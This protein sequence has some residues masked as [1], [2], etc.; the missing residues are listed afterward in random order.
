M[1][2]TNIIGEI[3]SIISKLTD[4][5]LQNLNLNAGTGKVFSIF[6]IL[7]IV[8]IVLKVIKEPIKWILIIL[9]IIIAIQV[10]ISFMPLA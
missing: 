6:I 5:F 10:G 4:F 3:T 1:D 7:I 8:Y 9:S 2:V